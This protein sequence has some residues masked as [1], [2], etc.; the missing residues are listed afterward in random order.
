MAFSPE[1]YTPQHSGSPT[2]N[3]ARAISAGDDFFSST[4]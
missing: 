1:R 4:M 3:Q 2:I